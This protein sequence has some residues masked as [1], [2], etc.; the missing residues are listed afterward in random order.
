MQRMKQNLYQIKL[1]EEFKTPSNINWNKYLKVFAYCIIIYIQIFHYFARNHI[2]PVVRI[3]KFYNVFYFTV[4]NPADF[5]CCIH[6]NIFIVFQIVKSMIIN[7]F[8]KKLIGGN[9]MT[10]HILKQWRVAYQIITFLNIAMQNMKYF[11][12]KYMKYIIT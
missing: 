9:I 10:F 6:C 3:N 7:S 5:F 12:N 1:A 4:K 8:L 2:L 11:N